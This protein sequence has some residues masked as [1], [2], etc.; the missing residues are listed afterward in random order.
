MGKRRDGRQ[1][2]RGRLTL[3]SNRRGVPWF[4]IAIVAL[5]LGVFTAVLLA[6]AL[7]GGVP[8]SR[9]VAIAGPSDT[10]RARFGV[11][12]VGPRVTCVVDGDTIW[13]RGTKIRIADIDTPEVSEPGCDEE[14][15]P[16]R[17]ATIRMMELLNEGPFTLAPNPDGGTHDRYGRALN[18]VTRGGESLGERLVDEGL[19]NRWGGWRRGWC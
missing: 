12:G 6:P 19:A 15:R 10:H 16:G 7:G 18:V 5:P 9:A 2:G 4:A 11:C 1:A 3:V 13:Y 14:A 8:Q 17:R